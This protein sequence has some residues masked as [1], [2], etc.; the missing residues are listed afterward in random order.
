MRILRVILSDEQIDPRPNYAKPAPPTHAS[1]A[2]MRPRDGSEMR[3]YL[4]DWSTRLRLMGWRNL[5]FLPL[6]ALIAA[7]I[8]SPWWPAAMLNILLGWWKVW[9]IAVAVPLAAFVAAARNAL[10]LRTDPFCIHCG[11]SVTGLPDGH[12]CPECG[13]PFDLKVIEEYRRD[14]HWFIERFNKRHDLP[15]TQATI[16]AGQVRRGGDGT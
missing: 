16:E 6:L 11:Y 14:P 13:E 9:V 2:D 7:F 1:P 3:W 12:N 15:P 4:P 5:L 8:L 10:R